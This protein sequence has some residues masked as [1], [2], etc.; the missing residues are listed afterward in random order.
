MTD[1]P[2][3]T[4]I[5]AEPSKPV[6]PEQRIQE[7]EV[8]LDTVKTERD[9]AV[10]ERDEA[11]AEL[12]KYATWVE[13]GHFY[14]PIPDLADVRERLHSIWGW[15]QFQVE[16]IDLDLPGQVALGHQFS[17]SYRDDYFHRNETEGRRYYWEN[18]YFPFGD[19]FVTDRFVREVSPARIVEIGSGYSSAVMLDARDDLIREGKP[20]PRLDFVEPYPDRLNG[21]LRH[22]D[23]ENCKVWVHPVQDVPMS[24]FD[25]LEKDDLLFIDS[26]HV[27]KTGSDLWWLFF[28]VLPRLKSG[29]WVFV[30]DIPWPF[31]Y[32]IEWVEEGRAWNEAYTLRAFLM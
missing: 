31:E 9:A 23:S 22:S 32:P 18:E 12:A 10:A 26:S 28:H 21:L 1:L 30:H 2:T 6:S 14:S 15:A 29:V 16:G 20:A 25:E 4:I 3:K 8:E 11:R 19:A 7:L 17:L 5:P 27:M 24:L 13:P